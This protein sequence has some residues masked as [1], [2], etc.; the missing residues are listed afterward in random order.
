MKIKLTQRMQIIADMVIPGKPAADIG[1]DHGYIPAYLL[2]NNICRKV[3]MTDVNE[4]PLSRAKEN[5]EAFGLIDQDFRLGNGLEVID[6][7]EVSTVIIAGMGGELISE[8]LFK[9]IEKTRSFSKIIVQPRTY[10]DEIRF[11]LQC[12]GFEIVD[13]K[14]AKEKGRICEVFSVKYTGKEIIENDQN[15]IISDIL[16]KSDDPLLDEYIQYKITSREN[17]L[18]NLANASKYPVEIVEGLKWGVEYLKSL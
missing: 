14:L 7:G 10:F 12:E 15:K 3:I 5:F 9:D 1:T 6:K 11:N 13:Y 16:L 17:I 4:G 2:S 8:I 18:N